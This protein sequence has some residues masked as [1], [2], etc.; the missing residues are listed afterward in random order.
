MGV[1]ERMWGSLV[2]TTLP[3]PPALVD[4]EDSRPRDLIGWQERADSIYNPMTGLGSWKDKGAVARPNPWVMPLTDEE[5]DALKAYNGIASRIIKVPPERACAKGWTAGPDIKIDEDKRLQSWTQIQEGMENA[6]TFGGSIGV[7]I[8]ED[9]V[10]PQFR[11]RPDL[12]AAQPLDMNRIGHLHALQIFDAFEA[13]PRI[14][15]RDVRSPN[16]RNPLLWQVNADGFVRTVHHSRVIYFRGNRRSSRALGNGWTGSNRMPDASVL[17]VVYDEIH[18]LTSTMQGGAHLAQE[19]REKVLKIGNFSEIVTGDQKGLLAKYL[20]LMAKVKSMLGIT[21]IGPGD[22]YTNQ[23]NPPTGFKD[24]S[25]AQQEM[26][27]L[28]LGWPRTMLNGESPG[29]LGSGDES[30]LERERQIITAYQE[31]CRPQIERFYTVLYASQDGPTRGRPPA[32]WELKFNPLNEP[33]D[34]EILANMKT[35]AEVDTMNVALQVY[36]PEQIAKSRYGGEFS[37][38]MLPVPIPDNEEIA[39][40]EADAALEIA[41]ASAKEP[42]AGEEK[43]TDAAD[44]E[45]RS[46]YVMVPAANPGILGEVEKAVGQRLTAENEPHVTVL[47]LGT[48]HTPEEITEITGVVADE[49]RTA[50]PGILER[51]SIRTFPHGPYGTPIV[52]EFGEGWYL[53]QLNSRLVRRLAHLIHARQFPRFRAHLTIGYAG[54]PLTPAAASALL[55]M[56]VSTIRVPTTEIRVYAG[57]ELVATA[58]VG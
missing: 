49:A 27:C 55:A 24:L 4:R 41:K 39:Q 20:A 10:P 46:V 48:G 51:G 58:S 35:A 40:L 25:D 7:M 17:Q 16:Y 1:F 45:D 8:T 30:G 26:L 38:Y 11:Q 33:K 47:Y 56:D 44:D 32:E 52:V 12:W 34:S 57:R 14:M 53:E 29:A 23:S 15:D 5:L 22:E 3:D 43:K 54:S 28:V 19:L 6:R 50:E 18:R 13:S 37:I 21:A 36:G 42:A 31:S 2:G 9:D